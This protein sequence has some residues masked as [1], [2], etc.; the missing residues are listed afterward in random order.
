MVA[1]AG[2]AEP[3]GAGRGCHGHVPLL[4]L[5]GLRLRLLLLLLLLLSWRRRTNR[6]AWSHQWA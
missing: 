1:A 2:S 5:L 4:W 6:R 3:R